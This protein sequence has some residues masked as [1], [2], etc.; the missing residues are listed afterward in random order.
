MST[1][2]PDDD[3]TEVDP[4][5]LADA[6]RRVAAADPAADAVLDTASL[7]ATLAATTGVTVPSDELAAARARRHRTRWFQ[8]A[9]AVAAVAV[10]GTGGYAWGAHERAPQVAAPISLGAAGASSEVSGAVGGFGARLP[11]SAADATSD[12]VGSFDGPAPIGGDTA[13]HPMSFPA[14]GGRIVFTGGPGLSDDRGEQAA[15][16]FDAAG[17]YSRATLD[18]VA[19]VFGV[20][21][22]VSDEYGLA[23][24][25]TDGTGP[26]VSLAPDG[27]A[28]V[29][30]YDPTRD[31]WSCA[32]RSAPD[33][34][35][36]GDGAGTGSGSTG[37]ARLGDG[38]VAVPEPG[39]VAPTAP[40]LRPCADGRPSASAAVRVAR[41]TLTAL[42]LD[43]ASYQVAADTSVGQVGGA[44]TVLATLVVDG[45]ASG[46]QWSFTVDA[47]GLQA[48][49][50]PLAPLVALGDY[51]VVSAQEAVD[52]LND[53]RF[54]TSWGGVWPL[55][56]RS[57][58]TAGSS[59]SGAVSP[60]IAPGVAP[61][62]PPTPRAGDPFA[63]PV[64]RVTVTGARLGV[65]LQTFDDGSS[66]LVPA[67]ELSD[68][69]GSTWSVLAVAESELDL[70]S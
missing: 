30:Y 12:V 5:L 51:D 46:V 15:W 23:K 31:P 9:A 2:R 68:G 39:L 3:G 27:L 16:G 47:E 7:H 65:A 67:Y 54:T 11:G 19:D 36:S 8:V 34:P 20:S 22:A 61:E 13:R 49:Y 42:G 24:G 64:T 14:Y 57:F 45:Q 29:S 40:A 69:S 63:W 21:G 58:D 35:S 50:G 44:T 56:M 25:S 26:S 66:A 52:R 59:A 10:V 60:E 33:R 6:L 4:E 55:A 37:A 17:V 41:D 53:P 1:Q 32:V 18:R 62:V 28:S 48:A 38:V 43:A 70:T